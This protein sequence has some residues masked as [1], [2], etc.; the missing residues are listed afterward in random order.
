MLNQSIITQSIGIY[1]ALIANPSTGKSPAMN[2]IKRAVVKIAHS[3]QPQLT[4]TGSVE[5]LLQHLNKL[6]CLIGI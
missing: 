2:V 4:N 6:T 1:S 5:G 3:E